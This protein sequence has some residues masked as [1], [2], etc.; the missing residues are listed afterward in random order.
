MQH[1]VWIS[2]LVR[3]F[4]SI[5]ILGGLFV[6][7]RWIKG[8]RGGWG[9]LWATLTSSIKRQAYVLILVSAMCFFITLVWPIADFDADAVET[10]VKLVGVTWVAIGAWGVSLFLSIIVNTIRWK[11]D[12][13]VED[14]LLARRMHTKIRILQKIVTV[15]VWIAAV[16]G[17]LM[18][19]DSFR[20][21]GTT[22]LA[23]AGVLS[24]ILGIS[25]QKTF[26]SMIAGIQIAFSHPINLDDVVIVEGEWGRV[27]EIT[28]TYV[29]VKIWD[30]RRLIV[31]VSY[32]LEKPFQ[33]WTR[34]NADITGSVFLH[35][36]YNTPLAPLRHEAQRICESATTL[37]DGKTCVLQV[38]DAGA[39]NMTVRVLASSPDAS[40]AWDL[41]CLLREGLISFV[42]AQYPDCLPRRRVVLGEEH[43]ASPLGSG[44]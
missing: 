39:E 18:Q 34:K 27:E 25:A 17:I 31:P 41:R 13:E 5:L 19:F 10:L 32:F 23:S 37:W 6:F 22:L 40:K 36:D 44:E 4:L 12:V 24:I 26:G 29:V 9:E 11:Y 20:V 33:N 42:Q 21:L 2:W 15:I 43:P 30:Q 7:L 35:L 3:I 28:F 1:D 16:S 8:N 14:N 38:T